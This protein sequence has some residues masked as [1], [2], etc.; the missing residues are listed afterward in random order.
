VPT[1]TTT[2]KERQRASSARKDAAHLA[3][4]ARREIRLDEA[5]PAGTSDDRPVKR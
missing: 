3:R 4:V 5:P 2:K 1:N